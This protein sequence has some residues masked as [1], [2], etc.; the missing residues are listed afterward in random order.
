MGSAAIQELQQDWLNEGETNKKL[1]ILEAGGD[2]P[3]LAPG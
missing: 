2:T 3:P 1:E